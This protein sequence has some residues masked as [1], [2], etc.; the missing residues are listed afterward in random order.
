MYKLVNDPKTGQAV[1]VML[2]LNEARDSL[3]S[4][5]FN[6]DNADYQQY[7]AWLAEGNT[8]IAADA[9]LEPADEQGAA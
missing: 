3:L 4:I 1:C 8:P 7:L 5:P 2:Y 9:A 6:P